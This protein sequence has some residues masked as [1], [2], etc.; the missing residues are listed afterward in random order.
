MTLKI[1]CPWPKDQRTHHQRQPSLSE[2]KKKRAKRSRLRALLRSSTSDGRRRDSLF[3]WNSFRRT[4]ER[5]VDHHGG[6]VPA[7]VTAAGHSRGRLIEVD[8]GEGSWSQA[9]HTCGA[10]EHQR[11]W[12]RREVGPEEGSRTIQGSSRRTTDNYSQVWFFRDSDVGIKDVLKVKCPEMLGGSAA[13][14]V[15]GSS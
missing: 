13:E 1:N 14:L 8:P 5:C 6:K 12:R 10:A 7:S 11:S 2:G 9:L 15:R 3:F 4:M